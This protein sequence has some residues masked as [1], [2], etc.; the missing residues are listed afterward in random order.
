MKRQV[1]CSAN[2]R[3]YFDIRVT[4]T[5]SDV[6]KGRGKICKMKI[7]VEVIC[8]CVYI[9]GILF[10]LDDYNNLIFYES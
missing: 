4:Q 1:Y 2:T 9:N 10:C 7:I 5:L 6:N 8:T 3:T